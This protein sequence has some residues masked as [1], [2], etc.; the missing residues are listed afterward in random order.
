MVR[1]NSATFS[2]FTAVLPLYQVNSGAGLPCAAHF[3]VTWLPIHEGTT[4]GEDFRGNIEARA[5][6]RK[7]FRHFHIDFHNLGVPDLQWTMLT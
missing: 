3:N 7:T 4:G 2:W 5:V 1:S 6:I